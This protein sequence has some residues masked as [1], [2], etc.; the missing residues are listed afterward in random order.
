MGFFSLDP[1]LPHLGRR[2]LPT[3]TPRWTERMSRCN[4]CRAESIIGTF[5][6]DDLH[7]CLFAIVIEF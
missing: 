5:S 1:V 2:L 6:R 4:D 3:T 7:N